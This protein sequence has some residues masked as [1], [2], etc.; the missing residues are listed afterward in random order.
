MELIYQKNWFCSVKR[1]LDGEVLS[2]ATVLQTDLEATGRLKVDPSSFGIKDARW[3]IFRSPGG[4]F[5]GS[6]EAPGLKGA[7]AYFNIGREIRNAVGDTAGGL[8]RD[9]L[10][11]C[12]RGVIQSETFLFKERGFPTFRAYVEHWRKAQTG[13]C[14]YHSNL[15]R[16]IRW[17]DE[18]VGDMQHGL[19]L[20]NRTKSIAVYRLPDSLMVHCGFSD[21]YHELGLL[22]RVDLSGRVE[23]CSS[24]FLRA[25]DQVCFECGLLSGGL[26]GLSLKECSRK[27]LTQI[28]GGPQGCDHLSDLGEELRK[29]VTWALSGTRKESL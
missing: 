11:E 17:W 27:Q 16:V 14:R 2:E 12:V 3:E 24:N 8:V 25:P 10:L 29:A 20:F 1:D 6:N 19:N 18:Y 23:D 13:S 9:L 22:S 26:K 21:T 15:H 5:N 7:S 4:V 28:A